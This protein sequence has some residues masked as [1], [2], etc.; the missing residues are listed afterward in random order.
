MAVLFAYLFFIASDQYES[1]ATV[2]VKQSEDAVSASAIPLLGIDGGQSKDAYLIQAYILSKDMLQ[3]LDKT[4]D[5]RQHYVEFDADWLSRL[6]TQATMEDYFAYYQDKVEVR[7]DEVSGL[8]EI[9]VK[10]FEPQFSHQVIN[11]IVSQ[12]EVFINQLGQ[13]VAQD[14]VSFVEKELKRAHNNLSELTQQLTDF[15]SSQ[16]IFSTEQQSA[17]V[18]ASLAELNSNLISKKTELQHLLAYMHASAPEVVTLKSQINAIESQI[19]EQKT[20]LVSRSDSALNQLDIQYRNLTMQIE[21]AS[22]VYKAALLGLEQ[23]RVEAHRKLKHLSVVTHPTIAD[24]AL[25]PRRVYWFVT[26]SIL[27]AMLYSIVV[28]ILATVK[29]HKED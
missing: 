18:L 19:A 14:E 28:M 12:A 27:M 11:A 13:Q 22:D 5:L 4:V 6:N 1:T 9:S 25:Y 2:V 24:E 16:Q 15:Q 29:E 26:I 21:F 10:T 3:H 17:A 7:F 20:H 23:T 8:I